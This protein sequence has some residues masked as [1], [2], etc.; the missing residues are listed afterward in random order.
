MN[1]Q[2]ITKFILF[3]IC[4]TIIISTVMNNINID[5]K[6]NKWYPTSTS[7]LDSSQKIYAQIGLAEARGKRPTM[8]DEST[9]VVMMPLTHS[10]FNVPTSDGTTTNETT[11]TIISIFDGHGGKDVASFCAFHLHKMI[12]CDFEKGNEEESLKRSFKECDKLINSL[13]VVCGSCA[14][15]IVIV[16]DK[17]YCANVGDSEAILTDNNG[18]VTMLTTVHKPTKESSEEKRIKDLGGYVFYERVFGTLA[19]SRAFGDFKYK[20]PLAKDDF[21]SIE[22][23]IKT[24]DFNKTCQKII[25]GCDGLWDVCTYHEIA[26]LVHKLMKDNK[27]AQECSELIVNHAIQKGSCDNVSVCIVDFEDFDDLMYR[28]ADC[29]N[30]KYVSPPIQFESK[31]AKIFKLIQ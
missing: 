6:S 12:S 29:H 13:N 23:D 25:V 3:W 7:S 26:Y 10:S 22:P 9:V 4:N 20:T 31:T 8:E 30:T 27:N 16:N 1:L 28:G 15:V 17:L 24:I 14:V 19:V 2:I 18:S 11:A 21:V 5:D